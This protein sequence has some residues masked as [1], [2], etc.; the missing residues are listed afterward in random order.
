MAGKASVTRAASINSTPTQVSGITRPMVASHL[1]GHA[2][3]YSRKADACAQYSTFY[4]QLVLSLSAECPFGQI[5]NS[6][7]RTHG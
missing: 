7:F 4:S 6:S 1:T 2:P 3:R 5:G